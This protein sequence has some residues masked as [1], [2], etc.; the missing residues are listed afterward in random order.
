MTS[1]IGLQMVLKEKDLEKGRKRA[2]KA[3]GLSFVLDR[4][5]FQKFLKNASITSLESEVISM[6]KKNTALKQKG[7]EQ[8]AT[9]RRLQKD[10]RNAEMKKAEA[11]YAS[12][13][14]DRSL[15]TMTQEL[16]DQQAYIKQLEQKQ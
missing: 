5:G 1:F 2:V 14:Q 12:V 4:A 11:E 15:K 10:L 7:C 3:E 13:Y 8:S 9:I 16:E 6:T